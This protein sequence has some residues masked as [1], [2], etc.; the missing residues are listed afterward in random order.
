MSAKNRD[1]APTFRLGSSRIAIPQAKGW[2]VRGREAVLTGKQQPPQPK[3]WGMRGR[4]ER[5]R[6]FKMALGK[7]GG[8]RYG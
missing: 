7:R 3:G 8:Q 1:D 2:G 5:G 4:E 6:A